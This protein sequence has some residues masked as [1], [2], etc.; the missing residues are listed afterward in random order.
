M[1]ICPRCGTENADGTD[2]C[3]VCGEYLRWEPTQ[4][5]QA[6]KS[7]GN[8]LLQVDQYPGPLVLGCGA[9]SEADLE[10]AAG[11]AAAYSDAPPGAPVTVTVKNAGPDR[12][13][14]FT[15][16]TKDQFKPWLV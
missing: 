13:L 10:T 15:T 4:A 16:P 6:L 9:E 7:P 11:L 14:R 5:I 8:F 12:E 2:F 3:V 1:K